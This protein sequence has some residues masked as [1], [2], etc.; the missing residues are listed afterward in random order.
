MEEY[1]IVERRSLNGRRITDSDFSAC[2]K[3]E[4]H[5]LT[6]DQILEIA[7]KAVIMAKDDAARELGSYVICQGRGVVMKALFFLGASV[8]AMYVFLETHI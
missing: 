8:I 1:E 7:K 2:P 5:E 6:E 3:F 4:R